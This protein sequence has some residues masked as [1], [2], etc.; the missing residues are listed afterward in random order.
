MDIV[1]SLHLGPYFKTILF[2]RQ[3]IFYLVFSFSILSSTLMFDNVCVC[4]CLSICLSLS[5]RD[6][7]LGGVAHRALGPGVKKT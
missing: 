6:R 4:V 1:F 7:Q 2:R 5:R 3:G